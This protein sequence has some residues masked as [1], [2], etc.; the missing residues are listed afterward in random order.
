MT[1]SMLT[2]H[3]GRGRK[4]TRSRLLLARLGHLA[5][6]CHLTCGRPSAVPPQEID[7][8]L[9]NKPGHLPRCP[10][11]PVCVIG[12]T[13]THTMSSGLVPSPLSGRARFGARHRQPDARRVRVPGFSTARPRRPLPE[14]Q[15][16]V[17]QGYRSHWHWRKRWCVRGSVC[18]RVGKRP[19]WCF[20]P[21]SLSPP[22]PL[23]RSAR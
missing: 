13:H 5:K 18:L 11:S 6:L 19:M 16:T 15:L 7:H 14:L 9:G 12:H 22:S 8:A 4:Q 10:P 1:A 3:H 2:G 21:L 20:T 17:V 23:P